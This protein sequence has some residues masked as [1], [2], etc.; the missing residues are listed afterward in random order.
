MKT[1]H[2][3][4][5]EYGTVSG[6]KKGQGSGKGGK[7]YRV[8]F[9]DLAIGI[10]GPAAP[11]TGKP[12]FQSQSKSKIEGSSS[13]YFGVLFHVEWSIGQPLP[14]YLLLSHPSVALA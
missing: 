12:S 11:I 13:S 7:E 6:A 14:P 1:S 9:K 4:K 2:N 3:L 5:E 8:C 10:Y